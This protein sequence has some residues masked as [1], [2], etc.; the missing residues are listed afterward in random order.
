M[1]AL[2]AAAR[3]PRATAILSQ[4]A[5]HQKGT[6]GRSVRFRGIYE[7]TL[8]DRGRVALPARYRPDFAG[9]VI[10][11]WVAEGCVAVHTNDS[12]NDIADESALKPA[13]TTVGRR[14]RRAYNAPS[15]D[16]DLDRQGRVL[17]PPKFRQM[18]G[19][20][21]AVVIV[22][23]YDCLEI[24]NPERWDVEFDEA[25]ADSSAERDQG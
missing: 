23:R 10:L 20:N 12:F 19:L 6:S 2:P 25:M 5:P 18:A 4:E 7:H 16:V 22:G 17:V 15:Y 11:S 8:D 14:S 3:Q 9:G 21:G 24:W 13:T 1:P